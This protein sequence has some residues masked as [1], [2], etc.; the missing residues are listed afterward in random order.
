MTVLNERCISLECRL[1]DAIRVPGSLLPTIHDIG[2][3]FHLSRHECREVES[4]KRRKAKKAHVEPPPPEYVAHL[5]CDAWSLNAFERNLAYIVRHRVGGIIATYEAFDDESPDSNHTIVLDRVYYCGQ[6]EDVEFSLK[7]NGSLSSVV[8][9]YAFAQVGS[10]DRI[11]AKR[12][13]HGI[14]RGLL[15]KLASAS[16][17]NSAVFDPLREELHVR[18][19]EA[20]KRVSDLIPPAEFVDLDWNPL[21]EIIYKQIEGKGFRRGLES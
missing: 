12:Y 20:R 5:A 6:K 18:E 10:K 1:A 8:S 9:E 2:R 17:G 15:S 3:E 19:I 16:T 13:S 7:L 14:A 11:L 21:K 4:R